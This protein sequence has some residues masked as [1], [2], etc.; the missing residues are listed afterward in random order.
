MSSTFARKSEQISATSCVSPPLFA[1]LLLPRRV[2]LAVDRH[3][4]SEAF[5]EALVRIEHAGDVE[6]GSG[7]RYVSS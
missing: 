6:R 3:Q 5:I 4:F 7:R 1:Y 2:P